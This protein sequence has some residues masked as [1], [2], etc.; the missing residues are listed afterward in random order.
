MTLI[1]LRPIFSQLA[2]R[3]MS[4]CQGKLGKKKEFQKSQKYPLL[5]GPS[6]QSCWQELY[7][8]IFSG[9]QAPEKR[10][11]VSRGKLILS[12]LLFLKM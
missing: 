12:F 7:N 2:A 11:Y 5:T 4:A 3:N 8:P 1:Q 10:I 9:L 6:S